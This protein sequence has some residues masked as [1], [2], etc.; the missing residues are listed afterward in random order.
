MTETRE[1]PIPTS[2]GSTAASSPSELLN[3]AEQ[4]SSFPPQAAS[5][6]AGKPAPLIVQRFLS[7]FDV[8][9]WLGLL[10]HR[11]PKSLC[12]FD[13]ERLS[14]F[15]TQSVFF[16]S[17]QRIATSETQAIFG[18]TNNNGCSFPQDQIYKHIAEK[19]KNKQG[20]HYRHQSQCLFD[21]FFNILSG[22]QHGSHDQIERTDA[23]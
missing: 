9:V 20:E 21:N 14:T 15:R 16:E 13:V 2:H 18:I 10:K 3:K 12:F 5:P 17:C 22:H 11:S 4:S 23:K 6:R 1:P 7:S 19:C 8:F